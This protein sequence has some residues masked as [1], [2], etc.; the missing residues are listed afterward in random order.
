MSYFS[1]HRIKTNLTV[2]I[3]SILPSRRVIRGIRSLAHAEAA[4]GRRLRTQA[5]SFAGVEA[6]HQQYRK[7]QGQVM[8]NKGRRGK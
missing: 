5:N 2:S 6:G 3:C 4:Y 1:G 7:V 8:Y